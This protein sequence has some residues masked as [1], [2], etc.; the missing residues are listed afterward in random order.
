MTYMS[1]HE[2]VKLH[3]QIARDQFCELANE[4]GVSNITSDDVSMVLEY[5][6]NMVNSVHTAR[7]VGQ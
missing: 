7:K 6:M 1:A 2:A 4:K 5:A 3:D